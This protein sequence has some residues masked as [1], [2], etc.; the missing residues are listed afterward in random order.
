MPLLH[1]L[2]TLLSLSLL[3]L[4]TTATASPEPSPSA[5]P[6]PKVVQFDIQRHEVPRRRTI[7]PR[8]TAEVPIHLE[9]NGAIYVVNVTVGSPPQ[10]LELLLDTGSSDT[11]I[12]WTGFIAC[13]QQICN[14]GSFDVERSRSFAVLS[15][16]TF[17]I[18]Y[19]DGTNVQGSYISETMGMGNVQLQNFTMGLVTDAT[20]LGPGLNFPGLM[21]VGYDALE[22]IAQR[23]NGRTVY[24]AMVSSLKDAGHIN[25][26]AYSLWLN[27]DGKHFTHPAHLPSHSQLT[28]LRRRQRFHPLRRNRHGKIPGQNRRRTA[29]AQRRR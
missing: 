9:E 2:T 5:E 21:G 13:R 10:Q 26:K 3:S 1:S 7:L 11:W 8:D 17:E 20:D 25:V 27:D 14:Y 6:S 24:P 16:G 22:S 28:P 15:E 4:S 12:P 29:H 18:S 23:T 19:V